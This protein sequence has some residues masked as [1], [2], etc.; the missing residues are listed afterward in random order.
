[1]LAPRFGAKLLERPFLDV[2]TDPGQIGRAEALTAQDLTNGF[3][4]VLGFEKDLELFLGSQKPPLL[5]GGFVGASDE[6]L[7]LMVPFLNWVAGER[8]WFRSPSGLPPPFPPSA[9]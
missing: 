9:L 5:D 6:L 4:D 7:L 3:T 1:M 2:L 8:E